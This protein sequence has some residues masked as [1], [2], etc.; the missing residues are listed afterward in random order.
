MSTG[1]RLAK[2]SIIGTRVVVPGDDGMFYSGVIHAVKTPALYPEN[3]NCINLTPHTRYSVR[4]DPKSSG[5]KRAPREY[6]A[7]ELIGPGFRGIQGLALMTGQKVFITFNG[8]E[9]NG[10]VINHR[11]DLDEVVVEISP[12]GT[13]VN[14]MY[15]WKRSFKFVAN[16]RRAERSNRWCT[17]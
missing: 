15:S 8:R 7:H 4:F 13:E 6:G 11:P 5:G 14:F 3:N 10:T 12:A 17:N 1:K 16:L 2:R 9:V